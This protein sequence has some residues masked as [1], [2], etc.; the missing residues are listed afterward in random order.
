[1][2]IQRVHL[3]IRGRVQGVWYRGSTRDAAE[4]IGGISGW[5]RNLPDGSVEAVAEGDRANLDRLVAWCHDGP[6]SA[7]VDGIDETWLDATGEF[8]DFQVTY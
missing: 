6:P 3:I 2:G 8:T 7:R 1:M 4:R 5:V